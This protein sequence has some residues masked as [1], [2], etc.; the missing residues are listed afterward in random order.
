MKL[1]ELRAEWV[2]TYDCP[3]YGLT[4]ICTNSEVIAIAIND[5]TRLKAIASELESGFKGEDW[6]LERI[7]ELRKLYPNYDDFRD[8]AYTVHDIT[9]LLIEA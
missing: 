1:F 5:D 7:T 9:N 8:T 6:S 2:E 4:E 3:D